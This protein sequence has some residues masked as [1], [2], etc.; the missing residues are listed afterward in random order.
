MDETVGHSHRSPLDGH[1]EVAEHVRPAGALPVGQRR[2]P[3]GNRWRGRLMPLAASFAVVA[4]F[5]LK[6][7]SFV[8]NAAFKLSLE[9]GRFPKSGSRSSRDTDPYADP[10]RLRRCCCRSPKVLFS[11]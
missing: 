7:C 3:D 1:G 10:V 9:V 8:N 5:L 6:F 4:A 2:V 11:C